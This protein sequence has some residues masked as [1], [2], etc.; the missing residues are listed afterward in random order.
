MPILKDASLDQI[1]LPNSHYGYSATRIEDLGA[2]EYTIVTVACDV[3][4]STAAFTFDMEAAI[5]RIAQACKLSPRADNL[6]LRLVAFDDM[7][8]ELHG[9]K[10]LEN[11]NIAD[12][13]GILRAG[14]ATALFDA[15]ENA[16]SSTVNYAQRLASRDFHANAI[17]F[18]I[19]DGAD[20]ASKLPAKSA[21]RA[22][23]GAIKSEALESFVSILIGVNTQDTTVSNYLKHFQKDAGF[24]QYVELDRADSATLAGLA[25]FVSR[26]I[27]AQSVA[28]GAGSASHSLVF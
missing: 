6:L 22:I 12:Y 13:A 23:A 11:C 7:F 24:S 19:T 18:V 27:L 17:L 3:S 16:V 25:D 20:N 1:D 21:Q 5:A 2:T 26:S 8:Q 15:T 14:G 10:L 28:L 4:G 9:F